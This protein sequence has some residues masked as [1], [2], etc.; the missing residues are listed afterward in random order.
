MVAEAAAGDQPDLAPASLNVASDRLS[1]AAA[2]TFWPT[3][4]TDSNT[5]WRNVWNIQETS[6][7]ALPALIEAYAHHIVPAPLVTLT[8]NHAVNRF[9]AL[10][11]GELLARPTPV[12]D[13][14]LTVRLAVRHLS[15]R[16]P[17][18]PSYQ[19]DFQKK[20]PMW[21]TSQTRLTERGCRSAA[22]RS[23]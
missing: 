19:H 2:S 8:A 15:L 16:L 14:P 17:F 7:T 11:A 22:S 10:P 5:N 3:M 9:T 1:A 18:S 20:L 21:K 6:T 4:I 13:R 23:I 12:R